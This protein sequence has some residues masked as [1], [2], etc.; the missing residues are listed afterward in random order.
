VCAGY[1]GRGCR[2]P[3]TWV[4]ATQ[5]L[6]LKVHQCVVIDNSKFNEVA[7][8]TFVIALVNIY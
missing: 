2:L 3:R 5:D 7:S 1:P 6:M 8:G 4:Q